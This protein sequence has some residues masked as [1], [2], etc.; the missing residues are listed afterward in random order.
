MNFPTFAGTFNDPSQACTACSFTGACPYHMSYG[1]WY[2]VFILNSVNTFPFSQ[3]YILYST[4]IYFNSL[5]VW[6]NLFAF[7]TWWVIENHLFA[8]TFDWS[9]FN[10]RNV[11]FIIVVETPIMII[12]TRE[13][14]EGWATP[15]SSFP[16]D[17]QTKKHQPSTHPP[18]L[19][20]KGKLRHKHYSC[21]YN[22]SCLFII[23]KNPQ[24]TGST[25]SYLIQL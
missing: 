25:K 22:Y 20:H 4:N 9:I 3:Q 7:I 1:A 15:Q 6:T 23:E 5:V 13:T 12:G 19:K 10:K 18:T 17:C 8:I 16:L 21:L 2:T 11:Y 14:S 24:F